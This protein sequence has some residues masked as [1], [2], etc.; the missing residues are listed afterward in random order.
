MVALTTPTVTN[1]LRALAKVDVQSVLFE[2]GPSLH[3]SAL[4]EGVVDEVHLY[5]ATG[6]LGRGGVRWLPPGVAPDIAS[7]TAHALG[8]DVFLEGY[9]HRAH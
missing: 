6:V 9:V 3:R 7:L 2:G 1:G 4:E 5:I 8:R